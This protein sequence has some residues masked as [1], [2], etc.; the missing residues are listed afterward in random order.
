MKSF[1]FDIDNLSSYRTKL[2]GFAIIWVILYHSGFVKPFLFSY[3]SPLYVCG[4][5][6][7]DIFLLLSGFGLTFSISKKRTIRE[8]WL[9]RIV[10]IY[11]IYFF[12]VIVG[13][14]LNG[15]D[16]V[17]VVL[18]K[19]TALGYWTN[20]IFFDWYVPAI[21]TLYALFPLIFYFVAKKTVYFI[22]LIILFA[23]LGIL[24]VFYS[25]VDWQHFALLYRIPIFLYGC[26]LAHSIIVGR[27][28][29]WYLPISII[30]LF[31]GFFFIF[32]FRMCT[33]CIVVA[34]ATPFIVAA[35]C[36]LF[37]LVKFDFLTIIGKASLE[38]YVIHVFFLGNRYYLSFKEY[39]YNLST[40][41]LLTISIVL[42]ILLNIGYNKL[43][44][45]YN[46][47]SLK[48]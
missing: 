46:N 39:D 28:N 35:L 48:N 45:Q 21:L 27:K 30:L 17:S 23:I 41:L 19:C 11:P 9:S 31:M 40:I 24:N 12:L 8:F 38:I 25:F 18:W 33:C 20:G 42:G 26:M 32:T 29:E 3:L 10:R 44:L 43:R 4:F 36:R 16:T 5:G 37:S 22:I 7:V 1:Y 14:V 34:F 13:S 2:M 47:T 15:S 6:G